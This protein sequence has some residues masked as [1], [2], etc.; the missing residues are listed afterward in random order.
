MD[1]LGKLWKQTRTYYPHDWLIPLEITQILKFST[2]KLLS[3]YVDDPEELRRQLL[4]QLINV[5]YDRVK[6]QEKV[7]QDV[8]EIIAVACD[9]LMALDFS[10]PDHVPLV[11]THGA[12]SNSNEE[13]GGL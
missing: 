8:K 13:A 1:D 5:R 6:L 3:Q 12:R 4:F 9:D 10:N 11:P 2:A 7:N